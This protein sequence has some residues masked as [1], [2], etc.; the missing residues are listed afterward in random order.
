MI[1]TQ[2]FRPAISLMAF[3]TLILG[4]GYPLA[5]TGIA[6]LAFSWRAQGSAVLVDGKLSGSAL[7]GQ[8]FASDRYF[9]PRPSATSD[10]PYNAG[11]ST[12]TNLGPTSDKLKGMVRTEI[13]RLRASGITGDL[14]ADAA[15]FSGSGLDPHVTPEFATAQ[16]ARIAKARGLSETDVTRLVEARTEGRTYGL[17]G[18][19]RVN[20][21]ALN[22]ALDALKAG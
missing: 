22:M 16:V 9:W 14:P 13:E 5:M 11:A 20:L 4:L 3:F 1:M 15:T 10:Q 2:I 18:E 7:I 19:P 21:L 17:F 8:N 6:Q 12:G